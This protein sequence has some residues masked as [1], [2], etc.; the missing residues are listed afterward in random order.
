MFELI[1]L[2]MS[3]YTSLVELHESKYRKVL[4]TYIDAHKYYRENQTE[5]RYRPIW[6]YEH[7]PEKKSQNIGN[8]PTTKG[9]KKIKQETQN[10]Q[11]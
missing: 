9:N 2:R 7:I 4:P 11:S 8:I 3:A 10:L 6:K 5:D 1:Y